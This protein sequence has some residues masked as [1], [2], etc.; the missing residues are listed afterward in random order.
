MIQERFG[1]SERRSCSL[2]KQNPSTQ[3]YKRKNEGKDDALRKRMRELAERYRRFGVPR[4][5]TILRKEGLVMNYKRTERV[6][7]LEG[8]TLRRKRPKKKGTTL[9]VPMQKTEQA[10]ECW[11]MDFVFD[12]LLS[13]RGI[14]CLTIVDNHSKICPRIEISHSISGLHLVR[15]LE[16]LRT[17]RGLPKVIRVDNGP[18]F[19]SKAFWEFCINNQIEI[20][21]IQPG[22]PTQN[23]YIES[24]NGKFRDECLNEQ[25]FL[26]LEDAQRKIEDW[27]IHYNSFRPHSSL[28]GLS[29]D[30]FAMK[31]DLRL[32]A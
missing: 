21:H 28:G 11:S 23:C 6:Y 30:E 14:K 32:T 29:P 24:F 3:Q 16:E 18:E 31:Q 10:N 8:L 5:H 27:R 7:H 15:A 9:R 12:A 22:K 19:Q 2:V 1:L 13:G 4:L 26:N 20:H 25:C 17:V